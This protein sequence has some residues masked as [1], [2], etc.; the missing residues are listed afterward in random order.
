M[1]HHCANFVRRLS[2][3]LKSEDYLE[4][5]EVLFMDVEGREVGPE[6]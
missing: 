3:R 4:N 5:V 1:N 2:T 6:T